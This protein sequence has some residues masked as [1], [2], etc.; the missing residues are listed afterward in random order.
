MGWVIL[1]FLVCATL[2]L[3][4]LLRVRGGLLTASA[5]ALLL[6]AVGYAVQGSP[7]LPGV[8]AQA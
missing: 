7:D 3:L 8:P 1:L 5:A 6:G 2:A 4:W